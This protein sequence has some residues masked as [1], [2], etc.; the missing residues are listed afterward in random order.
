MILP[1]LTPAVARALDAAQQ[2]ARRF[3][4]TEVQPC[5][6]LLGLL[7]EEEGKAAL[8][9]ARFG[10]AASVIQAAFAGQNRAEPDRSAPVP[11]DPQT[12]EIMQDARARA[13]DLA[14]DATIASDHV[15]LALLQREEALREKLVSVGLD[16]AKLESEMTSACRALP[17]DEPLHLVDPTERM[18]AA[19][20]LDA[21]SNRAREALRVIEDYCRFNLEDRF[22]SKELK[23]LRHDLT[24]TLAVLPSDLLLQARETLRDIGTDISTARE[25]ERLSLHAV[26]HANLKRLQEA[27]RSLEEFGK[28]CSPELGAALEQLRYRS[29]TLERAIVLGGMARRR[30]AEARLY[31][32]VTGSHCRA[33]LDWT[34]QEAAAGGAQ[35]I[36]LR[37]KELDDRALLE[38]ARQ[39]RRWTQKAGVLFILNDRPDLARLAEADGVHLGQE[40]LSVKDARRIAG[41]D[42]L[43]G[44]STHTVE[45][46]RQAILDGASYVGVGPAFASMTKHFDELAGLEFIRLATAETSLPAFILGGVSL[47]TIATAV[48]AGARRVAVSQAIC[49]AQDPR[50]V[51]AAMRRV[52]DE[53]VGKSG[54]R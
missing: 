4:A 28:L 54:N 31:I 30:L 19:R 9:L 2:W 22:L 49:Q 21:D 5:H 16:Y 42:M 39:V 11:V 35:M 45:Q 38:R 53:T 8:L 1:D 27:L 46:V 29:Y 23:Q 24:E 14:G 43:I 15:L 25:Q 48:A 41:P 51:A 44:V 3:G 32:L 7:N 37:E 40:D 34:I 26:V 18:D 10:A 50:A 13:N 36:Q 52:L 47:D 12:Q 17:M 20:I 33:G 6:L